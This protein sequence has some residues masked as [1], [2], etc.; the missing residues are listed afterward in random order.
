M[1]T[2]RIWLVSRKDRSHAKRFP[3]QVVVTNH[4]AFRISGRST[5]VNEVGAHSRFLFG[6]FSMDDLIFDILT[7]THEVSPKEESIS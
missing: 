2:N 6:H 1:W 4:A 3:S 7:N 5:R